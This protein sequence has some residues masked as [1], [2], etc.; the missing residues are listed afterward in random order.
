M[1]LFSFLRK[2]VRTT[3][4]SSSPLIENTVY[5]HFATPTGPLGTFQKIIQTVQQRLGFSFWKTTHTFVSYNNKILDRTGAYTFLTE[6]EIGEYFREKYPNARIDSF[7]TESEVIIQNFLR[8]FDFINTEEVLPPSEPFESPI[9]YRPNNTL[10]GFGKETLRTFREAVSGILLHRT[11]V[12]AMETD[13]QLDFTELRELKNPTY[14]SLTI[15]LLIPNFSTSVALYPA[16]SQAFFME[17]YV[18][19]GMTCIETEVTSVPEE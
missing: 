17:N 5:I 12:E 9:T 14:C 3:V 15:P 11:I 1:K 18:R 6:K 10:Y 4:R 16:F 8:S 19:M 2:G 13:Q 7:G